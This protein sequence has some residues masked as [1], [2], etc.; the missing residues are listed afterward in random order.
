[1]QNMTLCRVWT[2]A[3]YAPMH[4]KNLC[5]TY[6]EYEPTQI[7]NLWRV[8][9]YAEYESM[10]NLNLWRVLNYAEWTYGEHDQCRVWIFAEYE[11]MQNMTI[12]RV[13]TYAECETMQIS[14]I[15]RVCTYAKYFFR[16]QLWVTHELWETNL[17]TGTRTVPQAMA[18]VFICRAWTNEEHEHMQIMNLCIVWT[19]AEF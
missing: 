2:Y 6:V 7:M 9:T 8:W 4:S 18:F 14:N 11:P 3:D 5:R 12:C 10:Q 13:C 17:T 19:Y 16:R 1:M 15:Y